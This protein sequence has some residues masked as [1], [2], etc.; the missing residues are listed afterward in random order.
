MQPRGLH[1]NMIL[2]SISRTVNFHVQTFRKVRTTVWNSYQEKPS[3]VLQTLVSAPD[4]GAWEH[5]PPMLVLYLSYIS[6]TLR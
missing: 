3:L 2:L 4:T 5:S 6:R 1:R